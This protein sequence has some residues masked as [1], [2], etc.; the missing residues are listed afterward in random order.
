MVSSDVNPQSTCSNCGAPISDTLR[1]CTTCRTDIGAPNVR[2]CLTDENLKALN[3]RF[4]SSRTKATEIGC[5]TEFSDLEAM[6]KDKSGVVVSMP[7]NIARSLFDNPNLLYNN[8]ETLTGNGIIKPANSENDRHRCAVGG[9]LFGTYANLIVY[10][11]L[12]LTDE[13]LSTYGDVHCR[14]RSV[15]IDKRTSFL[16]SNSY[17]FVKDHNI[18]PG[19]KL[20][21]GYMACWKN[22]HELVLAKLASNLST[23]QTE[24]D[25]QTL[26]ISS[27]GQN[28][29][30]DNFIEAHIYETFNSNAIES[31]VANTKKKLNREEKMDLEIVM[32]K[33]KSLTEKT[34]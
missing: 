15:A 33:F 2:Y 13:G 22:R 31:M 12:S 18:C 11:A 1:Y 7:V 8:Y 25:W 20:P 5:L 21:S 4:E 28:R 32:D 24:S 3:K 10:G 9:L 34:K 19:N 29:E 27:D 26:F 6:I 30:N 23:G 14:L 16:E 17:K